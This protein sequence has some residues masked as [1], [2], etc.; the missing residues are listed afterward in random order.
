MK[1]NIF[2]VFLLHISTISVAQNRISYDF[3]SKTFNHRNVILND[4]ESVSII[5]KNFNPFLYSYKIYTKT[6]T[7]NSEVPGQ[8]HLK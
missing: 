3:I 8:T 1:K 4:K 6:T 2:W 7:Y 5:L